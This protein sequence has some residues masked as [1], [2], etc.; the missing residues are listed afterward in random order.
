MA[1]LRAMSIEVVSAP[2]PVALDP[3]GRYVRI[4]Y[5]AIYDDG[6]IEAASYAGATT[7]QIGEIIRQAELARINGHVGDQ[8]WRITDQGWAVAVLEPVGASYVRRSPC[9]LP[10]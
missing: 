2:E 10:R 1:A 4:G 6:L 8:W 9:A 3:S 7:A 5:V